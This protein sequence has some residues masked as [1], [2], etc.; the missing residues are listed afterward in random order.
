MEGF[1]FDLQRF[2]NEWKIGETV[3]SSLTDALAAVPTD[4]TETT[5]T[6]TADAT[7]ANATVTQNKNVIIDLGGHTLSYSGTNTATRTITINTG[8]TAVRK[9]PI[10]TI[11]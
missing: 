11:S 3:Y 2:A 8:A 10:C 9:R 5:I 7:F 1:N 4:G 6:L